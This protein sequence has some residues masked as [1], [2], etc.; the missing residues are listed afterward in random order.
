MTYTIRL[1]EYT[2]QRMHGDRATS[3][4][5]CTRVVIS[6]EHNE[7][8]RKCLLKTCSGYDHFYQSISEDRNSVFNRAKKY[9]RAVRNVF[10]DATIIHE[11]IE[12]TKKTVV[13]KEAI[14]YSEPID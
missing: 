5:P 9:A 3:L 13:E 8:D 10:A 2:D 1:S 4:S 6:L 7:S 14:I 11:K 12:V